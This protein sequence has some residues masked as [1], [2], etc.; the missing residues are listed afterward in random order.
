MAL[1]STDETRVLM[2]NLLISGYNDL[3][4]CTMFWEQSAYC[5]NEAISLALSHGRVD[6]P[7]RVLHVAETRVWTVPIDLPKFAP[8]LVS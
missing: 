5:R 7:L 2:V 8:C 6:E 3:Q 1:T 4:N